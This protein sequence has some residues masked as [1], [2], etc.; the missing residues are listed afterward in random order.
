[1]LAIQAA[2]RSPNA[3]RSP[4][5]LVATADDQIDGL[6]DHIELSPSRQL[7]RLLSI[8]SGDN[9]E[10][11]LL[12]ADRDGGDSW[13]LELL[14]R[15]R[16]AGPDNTALHRRGIVI[17][18]RVI[19]VAGLQSSASAAEQSAMTALNALGDAV[20]QSLKEW[21]GESAGPSAKR[22]ASAE[23]SGSDSE[24]PDAAGKRLGKGQPSNPFTPD[25]NVWL[26]RTRLV[27]SEGT[28]APAST[29]WSSAPHGLR[30][31]CSGSL[32]ASPS[33]SRTPQP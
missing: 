8:V 30:I 10:V 7:E 24:P 29:L 11:R 33:G 19:D 26:C 32:T 6:Q 2:P 18:V 9:I 27:P 14:L 17:A 5:G 20:A 3:P 1:M 4:K 28:S 15:W 22:H 23:A 21:L 12:A 25:Q 13:V 31:T 16:G